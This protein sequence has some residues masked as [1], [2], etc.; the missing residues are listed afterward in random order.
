M[1]IDYD[2]EMTKADRLLQGKLD[3]YCRGL[4]QMPPEEQPKRKPDQAQRDLEQSQ[5]S[6]SEEMKME[7]FTRALEDGLEA[8]L[9]EDTVMEEGEEEEEEEEEEE[10]EE[11]IDSAACGDKR[12]M[13][14][15]DR[16]QEESISISKVRKTA[17]QSY[18]P[19]RTRPT[20]LR[21]TSLQS[22][23]SLTIQ[24]TGAG[25]NSFPMASIDADSSIDPGDGKSFSAHP[26]L[27]VEFF[28]F[29]AS[30]GKDNVVPGALLPAEDLADIFEAFYIDNGL[31][32]HLHAAS[33]VC[34]KSLEE[35][36]DDVW[37]GQHIRRGIAVSKPEPMV[38]RRQIKPSIPS[39]TVVE[40]RKYFLR[41][42][43]SSNARG[44]NLNLGRM[45]ALGKENRAL[46]EALDRL[47]VSEQETKEEI[48]DGRQERHWFK[49]SPRLP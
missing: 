11:E 32:T 40:C 31:Y 24:S 42:S 17:H 36:L 41:P 15:L 9:A 19:L 47:K 46:E 48:S 3:R 29:C 16:E 28:D 34:A 4:K 10:G 8:A 6:Q 26:D 22:V 18:I 13:E 20:A 14:K 21:S 5:D 33:Y 43:R 39:R 35:L 49:T 37:V 38:R 7:E 12:T 23:D 30:L 27:P 2:E 44:L 45:T 1:D 25:P